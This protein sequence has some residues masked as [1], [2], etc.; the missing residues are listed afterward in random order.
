MV[1]KKVFTLLAFLVTATVPFFCHVEA[2][3]STPPEGEVIY[4]QVSTASFDT[5]KHTDGT[6]QDTD[7]DG[8]R[9]IPRYSCS[10]GASCP[11]GSAHW[12]KS[13]DGTFQL[14]T[15]LLS[16]YNVTGVELIYQDASKDNTII[17]KADGNTTVLSPG[18]SFEDE[19]RYIYD[20]MFSPRFSGAYKNFTEFDNTYLSSIPN[21]YEIPLAEL[22]CSELSSGSI[23]VKRKFDLDPLA[24]ALN[25]KDSDI[26]EQL[27]LPELTF[28]NVA[29]GW[30]WHMPVIVK[31]YGK[32]KNTPDIKVEIKYLESDISGGYPAS[33]NFSAMGTPPFKFNAKVVV[34]LVD[35]TNWPPAADTTQIPVWFG[36]DK[37]GVR[38]YEDDSKFITPADLRNPGDT[39]EFTFEWEA[40]YG[41][42]I[43]LWAAVNPPDPD[44]GIPDPI[45][46]LDINAAG[47][48]AIGES[49]FN[50]NIADVSLNIGSLPTGTGGEFERFEY[51]YNRINQP[52]RIDTDTIYTYK[53][54]R[55]IMETSTYVKD[56]KVTF[57]N[58]YTVTLTKDGGVSQS[59]RHIHNE[60]LS[61]DTDTILPA[62]DTPV[63]TRTA[64]EKLVWTFT[65]DLENYALYGEP[66]ANEMQ[67]D[68]LKFEA[69]D[70]NGKSDKS[71]FGYAEI[72]PLYY[73][74]MVRQTKLFNFR[75]TDVKDIYW[76]YVFND[77]SGNHLLYG[78][79][80][81]AKFKDLRDGETTKPPFGIRKLPLASNQSSN[82]RLISKGYAVQC[83]V[84]AEGLYRAGDSLVVL[85]SFWWYNGTGFDEV[86]LYFD[87]TNDNLYNVPIPVIQ[88]SI[89]DGENY[90][91]KDM[92]DLL[93]MSRTEFNRRLDRVLAAFPAS[94]RNAKRTEYNNAMFK[95]EGGKYSLK[96]DYGLLA[97]NH[98][99]DRYFENKKNDPKMLLED[100]VPWEFKGNGKTGLKLN[101]DNYF[102]DY[103]DYRNTWVFTYSLHP[104]VKAIPKGANPLT[105]KPLTGAILV[106]LKIL[107]MNS[108][109]RERTSYNYTKFEDTWNISNGSGPL[110]FTT[111]YD[112]GAGGHGNAFYFNLDWSALDDYST[113]QKW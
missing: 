15:S 56:I 72:N 71:D 38:A 96:L 58:N 3:G 109:D 44:D 89:T 35:N 48:R 97:V 92:D 33:P 51:I 8:T 13:I 108:Y 111:P 47:S 52:I 20:N 99:E 4:S 79:D 21:N 32:P 106:N 19:Y 86:D 50:N 77:S 69:F 49:N 27:G 31:W 1:L 18:K 2:S 46:S 67:F 62:L 73:Y 103:A 7:L 83:R 70:H 94:E 104:R 45:G 54:N 57:G 53:Q 40:D 6:W 63:F 17:C 88:S 101:D 11:G 112:T 22:D 65:F 105:A 66:K 78:P 28:S 30:R 14:A 81:D 75:V 91:I 102:E 85:P 100:T 84:D 64:Q 23:T 68:R 87:I 9:D 74:V 5:W 107:T 98:N 12:E 29:E 25:V 90:L 55:I 59:D 24:V 26:R 76:K 60:S 113:Q 80:G 37:L 93:S 34:T 82:N 41:D 110:H 16:N 95:Q 43:Y 42:N 10:S 61:V 36:Y 39:K